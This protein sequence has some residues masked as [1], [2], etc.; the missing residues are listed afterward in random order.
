[1][2]DD[3][4]VRLAQVAHRDE[5]L[6]SVLYRSLAA[7]YRS[8]SIRAKLLRVSDIEKEHADY[9]SE[10][11]TARGISPPAK[12]GKLKVSLYLA[13]LRII[14]LGLTLRI[15]EKNERDAV[16]HYSNMLGGRG[17]NEQE[18]AAA[19]AILEDE[20]VHE[21]EFASEESEFEEFTKHLRD[22]ILGTNDG[23]VESLS[24][25]TGLAG[26]YGNSFQ[27]AVSG[28]IVGIAGAVSMGISTYVG[29][30]AQRQ[31]HQGL[32]ERIRT[33]ARY[34]ALLLRGRIW[35][36]M[37]KK[38]FSN[39]LSNLISEA[40]VNDSRLLSRVMAEEEY[41]LREEN[42]PNPRKAGL[43]SG[44][45]N[46]LGAAVPLAPYLLGLT[47]SLALPL[48]LLL[49]SLCLAAT[50]L[51]VAISADMPAKRKMV[52]MMLVGLGS[53]GISFAVGRLASAILGTNV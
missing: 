21:Q 45:S 2:S 24:V 40:S 17:F 12:P 41:G 15:L 5:I 38:G 51:V 23:L 10:F 3:I 26:A 49:V 37:R 36:Y 39:E 13:F 44:F 22:A 14:G 46:M 20:F 19:K 50:G 28:L 11:L 8:D 47:V 1:M 6:A 52:E 42:L 27:V 4:L 18:A 9:W 34:V 30:K 35:N 33:T 25:T 32:L 48:S 7:L 16:A 29:V 43:Y 31:V 53:A